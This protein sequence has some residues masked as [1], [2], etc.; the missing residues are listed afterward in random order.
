VGDYGV[1]IFILSLGY[2]TARRFFST[3]RE[4]AT[5]DY[6]L[7]TARAIQLSLLPGE[8]P[9]VRGLEVAVRYEPMR[10]IG[11][12]LY[13]F[14]VNDQQLGVLVAD[15]TGHG[16]PAALVA[17]MA[18]VAFSSQ[19]DSVATPGKLLE[20]INRALCGQQ[21]EGQFVTATYVHIDTN[22]HC[23]RYSSAGHPPPLL[24]Q[25]G[26]RQILRLTSGGVF[27]G[28]DPEATY[29]AAETRVGRGDR[30]VIYTDGLIEVTNA[31]GEFF[32]E[33]ALQRF[34]EA[35]SGLGADEFADALLAHLRRWSSR[36]EDDRAFEDDVTLVVVSVQA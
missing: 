5:M 31:D 25:L 34:L 1:S 11:G 2:V 23:V 22:A 17:S 24:W 4:I 12:D 33:D 29:P 9:A 35:N 32:G 20:G 7:Q 30:L 10:T 3:Q 36:R 18:K 8:T 14:V 26:P 16:V 13:A 28:F 27:M 15:V 19:A 6:E 21:L